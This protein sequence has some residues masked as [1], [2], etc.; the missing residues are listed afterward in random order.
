MIPCP[1]AAVSQW[2]PLDRCAALA[3]LCA[4]TLGAIDARRDAAGN[5]TPVGTWTTI[6]DDSHRRARWS[7]SA[8]HDGVLSG[9]IVRL[10]RQPGED[11]NPRCSRLHRL[12][13]TTSPCS[14]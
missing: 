5:P 9:R 3:L 7:K 1:S 14:A 12:S 8:R 10:F 13:A 11:P 6:D 4:R 2:C